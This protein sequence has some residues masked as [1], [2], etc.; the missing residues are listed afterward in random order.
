MMAVIG[1]KMESTESRRGAAFR[2]ICAMAVLMSMGGMQ[3]W[4][5]GSDETP[6]THRLESVFPPFEYELT[7][8]DLAGTVEQPLCLAV[9]QSSVFLLKPHGRRWKTVAAVQ[10]AG[11]AV[12]G[13]FTEAPIGDRHSAK[14][15][16]I[17]F[18]IST[19]HRDG[20][21]QTTFYATRRGST[22]IEAETT[23]RLYRNDRRYLVA[24][25]QG[26]DNLPPVVVEMNR[27]GQL[28]KAL[29]NLPLPSG[30]GIFEFTRL[31][32]A[33]AGEVVRIEADEDVALWVKN[34]LVSK[35]GLT[36][37]RPMLDI[38]EKAWAAIKRWRVPP[39]AADVD[40]DGAQEI[41]VPINNPDIE[42]KLFSINDDHRSKVVILTVASAGGHPVHQAVRDE[43]EDVQD[44]PED[45]QKMAAT[46]AGAVS[47]QMKGM[48]PVVV[49]VIPA[50]GSIQGRPV[51][52]V[53]NT[54][55]HR[56]Q[57][58]QVRPNRDQ[59]AKEGRYSR[60]F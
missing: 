46:H 6:L 51:V 55:T 38:P 9:G 44:V 37:G 42:K 59:P 58:Y 36:V 12:S 24:Q 26:A 21:V 45:D 47:L 20:R 40:G 11:I 28:P 19:V 48:T 7:S 27:P 50:M 57:L 30:T 17:R 14:D 23:G 39:M 43:G 31:S 3:G 33:D 52:A 56:T 29:G 1:S 8:F 13:G 54:K 16:P 5:A 35:A 41:V 18:F 32:T 53:V 4:P 60:L 22:K 34:N 25:K 15:D 2:L 49:G 10:P